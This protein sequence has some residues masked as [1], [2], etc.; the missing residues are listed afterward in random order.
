[1]KIKVNNFQ[2]IKEAELEIKG[3]TVIVG[4]NSIGKSALARALGGVFTNTRGDSHVRNGEKTSS[5]LV[6]FDDGNEVLWEKGG[7]VNQYTVNNELISKVGSSVPDEVKALGVKSVMVDGRELHPQIAKQFQ[8]IFLLDLPASAL[9]SALSD[10]DAIQKLEKAS[11]KARSEMRDIKSRLKVKREDLEQA[12]NASTYFEGFDYA[13]VLKVERCEQ[14]KDEIE[15]LLNQVEKLSLKRDKIKRLILSL[16]GVEIASLPSTISDVP[17]VERVARLKKIRTKSFITEMMVSVGLSDFS[18]PTID[19]LPPTEKV[20]KL[21]HARSRLSSALDLLEG[22]AEANLPSD[23]PVNDAVPLL[24][25]KSKLLYGLGI[26][27]SRLS[28]IESEIGS[29]HTQIKSVK[30][31]VCLR[32]GEHQHS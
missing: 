14:Q 25:K 3:L 9:S 24:E 16:E 18:S 29:V 13:Q 17:D 7:G 8:T 23:L 4:E 30:C 2:S 22:V 26:A 10:V 5:V 11:S 27:K 31:P 1:M 28:E 20:E 6:S 21:S 12:R 15:N 19:P 32:E